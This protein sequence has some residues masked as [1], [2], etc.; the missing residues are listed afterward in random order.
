MHRTKSALYFSHKHFTCLYVKIRKKRQIGPVKHYH[1]TK[2]TSDLQQYW[3]SNTFSKTTRCQHY[4]LRQILL[5]LT[6]SL[7]QLFW[8]VKPTHV[9]WSLIISL[10]IQ[11][12]FWPFHSF[13]GYYKAKQCFPSIPD[14]AG[15]L[16][17]FWRRPLEF[18]CSLCQHLESI[19]INNGGPDAGA[20]RPAPRG[21]R[22]AQRRNT[23]PTRYNVL[24]YPTLKKRG[25]KLC[26]VWPGYRRD[27]F[28][29][30]CPNAH[31][32]NLAIP[33]GTLS[34]L[35]CLLW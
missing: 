17:G 28:A 21:Q 10:K 24:N 26:L 19:S 31:K 1:V 14:S 6:Y 2:T 11:C 23:S 15:L 16:P 25:R 5:D 22:S 3:N 8:I 20:S 27:W 35:L 29:D 33:E 9:Q 18:G 7:K 30:R 32:S 13:L 34:T 4:S 12:R